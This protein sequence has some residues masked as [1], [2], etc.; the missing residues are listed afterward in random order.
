M[1]CQQ[2]VLLLVESGL[3][4]LKGCC[5]RQVTYLAH[6]YKIKYS[7]PANHTTQVLTTACWCYFSLFPSN[8]TYMVNSRGSVIRLPV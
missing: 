6:L 4:S 5:I 2:W 7:S 1:C 3:E 8:L